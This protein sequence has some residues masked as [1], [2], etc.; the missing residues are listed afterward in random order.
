MS[1]PDPRE[2]LQHDI[3]R[4]RDSLSGLDPH[5]PGTAAETPVGAEDLVADLESKIGKLF[6]RAVWIMPYQPAP[7]QP[8][9]GVTIERRITHAVMCV[10]QLHGQLSSVKDRLRPLPGPQTAE[11]R[12]PTI[13]ADAKAEEQERPAE[14]VKPRKRR[15]R[16]SLLPPIWYHGGRSYSTGGHNPVVVSN[17][18]HD[19]LARFLDK[20]QAFDSGELRQTV[21]NVADVADKIIKKFGPKYVRRP[22][23]D[24]G[25]GYYVRVRTKSSKSRN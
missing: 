21:N 24:K 14:P 20:D 10:R 19:F 8:L 9:A 11:G 23:R 4:V 25:A 5:A 3:E 18:I 7:W 2:Q 6:A 12:K 17:E 16:A 13:R 15:H 1:D 22:G